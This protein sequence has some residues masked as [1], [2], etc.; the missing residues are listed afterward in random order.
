MPQNNNNNNVVAVNDA[1]TVFKNQLL[2]VPYPGV[3][4]NDRYDGNIV[5]ERLSPPSN[6]RLTLNR[7][8]SFTDDAFANFNGVDSFMYAIVDGN[9]DVDEA[10]VT[11]T[12]RQ[13]VVP[14]LVATGGRNTVNVGVQG[15]SNDCL[16]QGF[17]DCTGVD[18]IVKEGKKDGN[19]D[20]DR[21]TRVRCTVVGLARNVR[22]VSKSF[23]TCSFFRCT[24]SFHLVY[25]Y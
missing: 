18:I 10:R 8:G 23:K 16:L 6:G 14:P 4:V 24:E 19:I 11:L 7:D 17:M 2:T 1:Y 20:E 3:L 12:V 15:K 13:S 5:V 9:Q 22:I 25:F 21:T